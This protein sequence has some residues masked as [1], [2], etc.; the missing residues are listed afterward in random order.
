MC[1]MLKL[2]LIA[3]K[4]NALRSVFS[5]SMAIHWKKVCDHA[6]ETF[7]ETSGPLRTWEK[8][9]NGAIKSS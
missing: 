9:R 1:N 8:E 6:M 7:M 5:P 3:A 2:K 4:T